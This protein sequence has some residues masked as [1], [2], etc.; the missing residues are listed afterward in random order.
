MGS[1]RLGT[2]GVAGDRVAGDRV[3]GDAATVGGH[4][5]CDSCGWADQPLQQVRRVYVVLDR[6]GI[7]VDAQD[8]TLER[9]CQA[10]V[11]TYP[12]RLD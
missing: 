2:D 7:V 6:T 3:A 11:A 1:H 12:H 9:W 8:G 4:V 5:T 10:C